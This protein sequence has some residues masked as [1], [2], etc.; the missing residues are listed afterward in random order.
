[1]K[2]VI[3]PE[4]E[5]AR[6]VAD[7]L[8]EKVREDPEALIALPGGRTPEKL[9]AELVRR[10]E[11]GELHVDRARFLL[12]T[13]FDPMDGSDPRSCRRSLK[14]RF[15]DRVDADPERC[16]FPS[17]ENIDTL[18]EQI[19]AWGGIDLAVLGIGQNGH[20]A[21]NEP[22]TKFDAPSHRQKLSP[23]TRRTLLE[24]YGGEQDVPQ[25]AFTVG[26][27]P[28]VS[29]KTIAVMAF[30]KEKAGPV[31]KMLYARDDSL[32]PAA[33]LQIPR[34]VQVYIDEAAASEIQKKDGNM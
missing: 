25:Y 6:A 10:F 5:A 20:F 7:L 4:E 1:M 19:T 14:E 28:I 9:Y 24:Q 31:F 21:Y 30:G 26:I 12:L 13:E 8:A 22:T 16:I 11:A 32:V 34:D 23:G 18:D 17:A 27:R 29:A 33:F 15:L 3:L 2:T